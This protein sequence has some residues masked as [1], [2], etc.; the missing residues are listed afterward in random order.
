[1][2][3]MKY[4]LANLEGFTIGQLEQQI[5]QGGKLVT[6]AWTISP[7]AFTV[8]NV[9]RVYLVLPGE[10]DRHWIMPT[11]VTGL[12]GWWSIPN[13]FINALQSIKVNRSG[14]LDVTDDIMA[15]LNETS[16]ATRTV[17]FKVAQSLFG[18]ATERNRTLITKAVNRAMPH[19]RHVEEIYLGRYI[20]TQEG[21]Q[22]F[23]V[24][25]VR[26]VEAIDRFRES[27]LMNLRKDFY[28]HVRFEIIALDS[29]ELA[30]KLVEQGDR[31][32]ILSS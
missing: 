29:S 16:L 5:A 31:L 7:I 9:T 22:P 19:Y 28:K 26:S 14:G 21:E 6:Y 30:T 10:K 32:K 2:S 24:I 17:E 4:R 15:N 3:T 12:F 18:K 25:G 23:H 20:N 13:G 1:M 11:I 27:L 8:R